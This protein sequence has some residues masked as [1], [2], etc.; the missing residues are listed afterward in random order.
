[1]TA[2]PS[3][4]SAALLPSPSLALA[5]ERIAEL[6][7]AAEH[8]GRARIART[9]RGRTVAW[10]GGFVAALRDSLATANPAR[11]VGR[12]GQVCPTC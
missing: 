4:H 11:L 6:R 5:H 12:N 8:A 1:M 3:T 2:R 7:A 9:V 10:P